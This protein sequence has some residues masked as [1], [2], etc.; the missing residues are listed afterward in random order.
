[1]PAYNPYSHHQGP[2]PYAQYN[3]SITNDYPPQSGYEDDI[4]SLAYLP[5][6][7]SYGQAPYG[8]ESLPNAYVAAPTTGT[9]VGGE[10]Q[11]MY[12][13]QGRRT[14]PPSGLSYNHAQEDYSIAQDPYAQDPYA[15]YLSYAEPPQHEPRPPSDESVGVGGGGRAY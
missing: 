9:H 11:E 7:A 4:E 1:M 2:D 14:S 3:P 8:R 12:L 15:A 6:P 5:S 13:G 10:A